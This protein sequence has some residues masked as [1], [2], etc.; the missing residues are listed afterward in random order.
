MLS[1]TPHERTGWLRMW[2]RIQTAFKS[3]ETI[4]KPVLSV[5]VVEFIDGSVWRAPL[6]RA[7]K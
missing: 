6:D 1:V 5:V 3:D 7:Q 4:G 2:N